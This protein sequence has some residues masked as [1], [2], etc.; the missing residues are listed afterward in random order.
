MEIFRSP[1]LLIKDLRRHA[2][3]CCIVTFESYT[4]NRTLDRP[5]FGEA[6]F[7]TN[8]IDALHVIPRNNDWYQYP[9]IDEV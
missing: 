5:G 4:D 9:E 7:D 2:S 8:D 6:F 1:N 3:A